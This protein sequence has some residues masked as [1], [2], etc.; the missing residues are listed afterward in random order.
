[1][2]NESIS[3]DHSGEIENENTI[4]TIQINTPINQINPVIIQEEKPKRKYIRKNPDLKIKRNRSQE[5]NQKIAEAL[6]GRSLSIE[7][8]Q[9]ISEAMIGNN[10]RN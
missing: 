8:K 5:H 4:E 9:A 10:N 7:H 6:R 1:M 2:N 3:P